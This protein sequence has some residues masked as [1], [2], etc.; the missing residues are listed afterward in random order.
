[1]EAYPTFVCQGIWNYL[2]SLRSDIVNMLTH[3]YHKKNNNKNEKYI[4][5]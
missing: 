2:F 1:M 5:C 4:G 3:I